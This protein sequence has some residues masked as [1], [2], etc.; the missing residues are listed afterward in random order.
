MPQ[1]NQ[2]K[3]APSA[4]TSEPVTTK[5]GAMNGADTIMF[6]VRTEGVKGK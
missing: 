2:G 1:P 5:N 3:P 4:N 6:G